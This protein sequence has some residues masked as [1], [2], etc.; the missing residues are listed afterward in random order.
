MDTCE[1]R[2]DEHLESRAEDFLGFI[3][4]M[5]SDDEAEKYHCAFSTHA[6]WTNNQILFSNK[7][8]I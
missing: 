8:K 7:W 3:D 5:S 1:E 2:I 6:S 4:G